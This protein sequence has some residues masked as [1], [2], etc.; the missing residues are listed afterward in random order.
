VTVS[1]ALQGQL[2]NTVGAGADRLSNFQNLTGS[3]FNDTLTGDSNNNVI[4]GGGGGDTL[5]G[6][7][8]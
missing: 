8:A 3:A 4:E 1:L 6:G 7:R 2:Q 5:T